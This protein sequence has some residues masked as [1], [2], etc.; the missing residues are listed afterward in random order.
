MQHQPLYHIYWCFTDLTFRKGTRYGC[1]EELS[2]R[3]NLLVKSSGSI[4]AS[5]CTID[6][7]GGS[8]QKQ[9]TEEDK[10]GMKMRTE[11]PSFNTDMVKRE[12]TEKEDE[13]VPAG[14]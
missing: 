5:C 9:Q 4:F 7:E 12:M 10:K 14:S 11:R 13:H 3:Y 8:E 6:T 1:G 2:S